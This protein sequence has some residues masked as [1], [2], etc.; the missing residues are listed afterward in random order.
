MHISLNWLKEF[1]DIPVTPEDLSDILTMLGLEIEAVKHPGKEIHNVLAGKI[2]SIDPHPDAD[3]LVVCKTDVGGEQPLQ[4]VCGAK[5]M[6]PGDLVPTALIGGNLPGGFEIGRRKMRG[7][8][9]QGMMCSS[10]ELGLGEDQDGLLILEPGVSIGSDI[11][12]V[13]GLDDVIYEVEITPNR[14][15]WAGM[16]GVAR[17]LAAHFGSELRMPELSLREVSPAASQLSSVTIESPDL[18][19]RYLGRV[20]HDV[21]VGESPDWLKRRLLAAG[22]RPINNIV[23]ITN[24]VLLETAHPLHAFDFDKLSENRIIVRASKQNETIETLDGT[25]R[26]LPTAALVIADAKTPV[27]VAGIMGGRYSEVTA[28]TNRIFLESAAFNPAS[29]RKTS[30]SLG[31]ATEASQRFQR[32][33]DVEMARFA[34]DRAAYLMQSIAGAQVADGVIDTY[35]VKVP[36]RTVSLRFDRTNAMI[37]N[38]IESELQCKYL[39]RLGFATSSRDAVSATFGIPTWR[40]DVSQEADLIEEVARMHGYDKLEPKLAAVRKQETVVDPAYPRMADLRRFLLGA[41]LTE[42]VNLSFTNANLIA[43]AGMDLGSESLVT[44]INPLSENHSAMRH[45]LLPGLFENVA[46][47]VRFGANRV[48]AFEIGPCYASAGEALPTQFTRLGIVLYGESGLGHWSRRPNPYDFFDAKGICEAVFAHLCATPRFEPQIGGPWQSGS[49]AAL[50]SAESKQKAGEC[51]AV[52][53]ST[54]RRF[55]IPGELFAAEL[56]IDHLLNIQHKSNKFHELPKFPAV[57]RD[58]AVL[59]DK[60]LPAETLCALTR[61]AGGNL[62]RSV[63]VFDVYAGSNVPPRKKSVAV[64]YQLQSDERTL[65]DADVQKVSTKIISMLEREIGATQR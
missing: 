5:N 55:D 52:A 65:T 50:Y 54:L 25:S 17:E 39:T 12:S 43:K 18:C 3:K 35:P 8:E 19:P 24:L 14:G 48:C 41:G 53:N 26:I 1:V 44:L 36:V 13:L 31:L 23:D 58:L 60:T 49:A 22:Q 40:P 64:R 32:G 28:S 38:Y 6:K 15:D 59:V 37:G 16:I 62:L 46:H 20:L 30:R 33:C 29:I 56:E 63:S 51:G 2:L 42:F 11:R 21:T 4:I 47:N 45:S 7:V 61:K 27:A 34:V 10:R 57:E 9:S